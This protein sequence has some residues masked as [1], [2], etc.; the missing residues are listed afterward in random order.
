VY[1]RRDDEDAVDDD[2]GR[3]SRTEFVPKK[4][5]TADEEASSPVDALFPP[6][7]TLV[8]ELLLMVELSRGPTTTSL[9]L[10]FGRFMPP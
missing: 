5:L 7:P 1:V 4:I 10:I 6:L 9:P 8:P 3:L 2:Y